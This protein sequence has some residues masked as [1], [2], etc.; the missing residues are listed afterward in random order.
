MPCFKSLLG[1]ISIESVC[2]LEHTLLAT[3]QLCLL[4]RASVVSVGEHLF[5]CRLA[6]SVRACLRLDWLGELAHHYV[7]SLLDV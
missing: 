1:A 5:L 3:V 4:G 6:C 2:A 7:V